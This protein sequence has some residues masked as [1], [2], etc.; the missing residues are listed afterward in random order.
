MSRN[1]AKA[2]I[3]YV[4]WKKLQASLLHFGS[5]DS[6]MIPGLPRRHGDETMHAAH[7]IFT[8]TA[9]QLVSFPGNLM[10]PNLTKLDTSWYNGYMN[11]TRT[12]RN[13]RHYRVKPCKSMFRPIDGPKMRTATSLENQGAVHIHRKPSNAIGNK[14]I[15]N[16]VTSGKKRNDNAPLTRRYP[17][18]KT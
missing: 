18:L 8:S 17:P 5:V 14:T 3:P 11:I 16:S 6:G 13:G 12:Y 10:T 9:D 15:S 1:L 4:T 7:H 2:S